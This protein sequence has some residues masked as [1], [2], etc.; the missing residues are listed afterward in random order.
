MAMDEGI[1][2]NF[3]LADYK[4]KGLYLLLRDST[5]L[6]LTK[7]NIEKTTAEYWGNPS[8]IPQ[9]VKQTVE[10]LRCPFC[11][12][13]NR[14]D[15]CD[16]LRPI[17]PFLDVVDKYVSIDEVT[18]IY[19]GEEK[20]LLRI[21]H[22]TMQEALKY[23]SILSLTQYCQAGRKYWKYF[24]GVIPLMSP[25]EIAG[26]EYLNAYWLHDGN[27]DKIIKVFET[28]REDITATSRNQV[29]RLSLI[30]KNDA[31]LNAFVNTQVITEFLNMDIEK[32]TKE[33]FEKFESEIYK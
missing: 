28:F 1:I 20:E 10:F 6:I 22:T 24:Y 11:P 23:V 31:F 13:K 19:K 3:R 8:K 9:A 17:L 27:R 14:N 29:K 7:S 12:L 4:E 30:C 21:A 15:F 5:R 32:I 25:K 2:T 26:R 16:A 33:S 18:A